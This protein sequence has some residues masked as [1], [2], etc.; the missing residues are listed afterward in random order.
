MTLAASQTAQGCPTCA[1]DPKAAHGRYCPGSVC[2]CSHE[3]CP[4]FAADVV[5]HL[6]PPPEPAPVA[7]LGARRRRK[8]GAA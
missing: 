8:A 2:Y 7:D 5:R 1:E 4:S 3:A 6:P